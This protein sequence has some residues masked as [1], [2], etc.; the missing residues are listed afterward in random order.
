MG[1]MRIKCYLHNLSLMFSEKSL[2]FMYNLSLMSSEKA[3]TYI[4]IKLL[5]R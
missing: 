1:I 4:L 5:K 2:N 3:L